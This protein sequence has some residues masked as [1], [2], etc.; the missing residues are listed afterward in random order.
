MNLVVPD[1]CQSDSDLCQFIIVYK[2][3]KKWQALQVIEKYGFEILT[4]LATNQAVG[5][6]NPSMRAKF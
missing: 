5:G 1:L 4:K 2:H 3:F 6:S